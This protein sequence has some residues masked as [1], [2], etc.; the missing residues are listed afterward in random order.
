MYLDRVATSCWWTSSQIALISSWSRG[1][2]GYKGHSLLWRM[3]RGFHRHTEILSI[4]QKSPASAGIPGT[5][6]SSF[7]AQHRENEI[8]ERHLWESPRMRTGCIMPHCNPAPGNNSS[9]PGHFAKVPVPIPLWVWNVHLFKWRGV[10][11]GCQGNFS[12]S[13]VGN[14]IPAVKTQS[15]ALGHVQ[16]SALEKSPSRVFT[17]SCFKL[18]SLNLRGTCRDIFITSKALLVG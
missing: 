17:V 4:Q 15:V 12:S 18:R 6:H 5:V 14:E 8:H 11:H 7:G 2:E 3:A 10:T 1:G 16:Y 13:Q 9:D